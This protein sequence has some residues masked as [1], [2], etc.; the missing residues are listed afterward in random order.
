MKKRNDSTKRMAFKIKQQK[1]FHGAKYS[2][3]VHKSAKD[4]DRRREKDVRKFLNEEE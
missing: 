3:R 1:H 4:Y 2:Q